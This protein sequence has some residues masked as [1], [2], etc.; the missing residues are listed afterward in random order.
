MKLLSIAG[1]V[2]LLFVLLFPPAGTLAWPAGWW[3]FVA[4]LAAIA[5]STVVVV[6]A[7]PEI[8]ETR[9]GVKPGTKGWDIGLVALLAAAL[10]AVP[11]TAGLDF[12]WRGSDIPLLLVLL[13][14]PLLAAAFALLAWAQAENGFFEMGV[15]IQK[16]RG[17]IVVD[18][19]PYAH[20]RHPGYIGTVLL[21]FG[22]ALALGSWWALLPAALVAG[23]LVYR[24]LLE[25]ETLRA[26]LAGY[27]HYC[28]QVRYR[29]IPRIW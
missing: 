24:T 14:Y 20:V 7:S 18:S 5:V 22:A 3:F 1:S 11:V 21:G 4:V 23:I 13:G 28:R 9:A 25:E 15:R 29:W 10:V 12:R 8:F 26:E 2:L 27:A 17:H 19:G 16:E 6:R